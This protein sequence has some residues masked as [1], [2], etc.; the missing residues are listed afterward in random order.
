MLG[1]P[2]SSSEVT[3]RKINWKIEKK[4]KAEKENKKKTK[5]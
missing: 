2:L 5:K 3:I 1:F 4:T